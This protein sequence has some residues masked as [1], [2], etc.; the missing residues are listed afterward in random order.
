MVKFL[1]PA[2]PTEPGG[3]DF[4]GNLA[5]QCLNHSFW[6]VLGSPNLDKVRFNAWAAWIIGEFWL[7][8]AEKQS[9]S[10][11]ILDKWIPIVY[12]E[13]CEG[14]QSPFSL[15]QNKLLARRQQK[16]LKEGCFS[17]STPCLGGRIVFRVWLRLLLN[18]WEA[19][20]EISQNYLREIPEVSQLHPG[21]E[22]DWFFSH[23]C[24]T[25]LQLNQ[26]TQYPQK[27]QK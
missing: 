25:D 21:K 9:Q 12:M 18:C 7:K 20:M 4:H 2:A 6:Q 3:I 23:K 22:Q 13:I 19:G 15:W 17:F 26:D 16:S 5:V 14:L 1:E 10:N 8:G 27:T 11:T 24:K